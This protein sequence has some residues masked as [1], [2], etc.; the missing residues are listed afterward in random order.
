MTPRFAA[1]LVGAVASLGFV[2]SALAQDP[3]PAQE[4]LEQRIERLVSQLGAERY[5]EREAAQKELER[6]GR[7]ALPALRKAT[8]SEDLEVASRAE[9]AVEAITKGSPDPSESRPRRA[10]LP[11]RDPFRPPPPPDMDEVFK[12]LERQLPK[13]FGR[14]FRQFFPGG[15]DRDEAEKSEDEARGAPGVPRSR[16]RTWTFT[17]GPDGRLRRQEV[18]GLSGLE[19]R[20]GLSTGP[21]SAVLR[22]QLEL[23]A[24][25][26]RVVNRLVPGG[27]AAEHGLQLYDV[28]VGV[29]GRAVRKATDLRPLLEK[30]CKVEVFRKAKLVAL[31]LPPASEAREEP[32][33]KE[34]PKPAPKTPAPPQKGERDF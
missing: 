19:A 11:E 9:A 18:G 27:W 31:D 10:P 2:P 16:V 29:D 24:G 25:E 33:A 13:G 3:A 20:L 28:I 4:S 17:L 12:E 23:P 26:G 6:I 34:A 7:P 5:D 15:G 21:T 8:K 32:G 30:G 14:I 22:A 1:L